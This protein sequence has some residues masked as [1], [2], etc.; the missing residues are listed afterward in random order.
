M[1]SSPILYGKNVLLLCLTR[2]AARVELFDKQTGEISRWPLA[3]TPFGHNTPLLINVKG[4]QQLVFTC[5]WTGGPNA[6]QP[7]DP[8]SGNVL[9]WCRGVGD[10]SSPAFG[11]GLVYFDSGRGGETRE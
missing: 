2:T 11:A 9:W 3:D 1:G 5:Q 10:V 6:L 4:K 7:L 8:D